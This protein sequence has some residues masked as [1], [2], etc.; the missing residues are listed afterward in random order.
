MPTFTNS[1][2]NECKLLSIACRN[3]NSI[4]LRRRLHEALDNLLENRDYDHIASIWYGIV[5]SDAFE[6]AHDIR[7]SN[8]G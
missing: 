5:G 2:L 7:R 6:L 3:A 8:V 4:L 1:T